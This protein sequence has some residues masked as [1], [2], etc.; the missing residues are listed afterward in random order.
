MKTKS[1][2]IYEILKK[3]YIKTEENVI[4]V[5]RIFGAVAI[6]KYI[7]KHLMFDEKSMLENKEKSSNLF[8]KCQEYVENKVDLYWENGEPKFYEKC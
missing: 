2:E 8:K 1:Y 6:V 7:Q 4:F 5:N 3:D